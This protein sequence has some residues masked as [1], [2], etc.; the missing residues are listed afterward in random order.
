MDDEA[1]ELDY[2]I[3]S[4]IAKEYTNISCIPHRKILAARKQ[5]GCLS[6]IREDTLTIDR[7]GSLDPRTCFF[8]AEKDVLGKLYMY[9]IQVVNNGS[10]GEII[11]VI[12]SFPKKDHDLLQDI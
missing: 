3:P 10:H 5:G 12:S 11:S 8:L 4:Q 6:G 1:K 2:S 7:L 9:V